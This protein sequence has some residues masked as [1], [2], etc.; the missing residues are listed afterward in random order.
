MSFILD[1]LRKSETERQRQSGPGLID[2]GYR[3]PASRRALWLPVLAV[4]LLANLAVM[5]FIW[6]RQPAPAP[7]PV[8]VAPPAP[9]A[10]AAAPPAVAEPAPATPA[11]AVAA[12]DSEV[13]YAT[14]ADMPALD[15][16]SGAA[17]EVLVPP[18]VP[19]GGAAATEVAPGIPVRPGVIQDGLP[20]ADELVSRGVLNLPPLHLD[21]HVFTA[22]PA[23]RFV[24]INMRKYT[25]GAVL[26][27]GPKLEEITRDGAVLS[28]QGRRFV[29][30]RD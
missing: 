19:A 1:A 6:L 27:E 15:P 24:F 12:G 18:P 9:A 11:A 17:T 13:A 22:D 23:G 28:E 5:A 16:Q 25:E 21:I 2:A 10:P 14:T 7:A 29:L 30:N 3:P 20:T 8:A 4:V 26:T